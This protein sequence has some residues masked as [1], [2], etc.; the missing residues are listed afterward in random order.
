MG[1]REET[2]PA[3]QLAARHE[4]HADDV[5]KPPGC[6]RPDGGDPRYARA[7]AEGAGHAEAA[8]P[9]RKLARRVAAEVVADNVERGNAVRI[10][11]EVIEQPRQLLVTRP[12]SRDLSSRGSR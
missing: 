3:A 1:G 8:S 10:C 5:R 4:A 11:L 12:S 2:Q 6:N 9:R 7:G